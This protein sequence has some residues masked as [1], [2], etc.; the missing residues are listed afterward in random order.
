MILF[1]WVDPPAWDRNRHSYLKSPYALRLLIKG[2]LTPC[3]DQ[4]PT[5]QNAIKEKRDVKEKTKHRF[6]LFLN[7]CLF[8]VFFHTH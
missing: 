6:Y 5:R 4:N 7:N 3:A 8:Y 2:F 1:N